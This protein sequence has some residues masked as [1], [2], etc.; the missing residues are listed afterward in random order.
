MGYVVEFVV[1]FVLI[2]AV[3]MIAYFITAGGVK[4]KKAAYQAYINQNFSLLPNKDFL[5][6][7]QLSQKLNPTIVL[8]VDDSKKDIIILMP[9]G[10]KGYT[11][12]IYPQGSLL[13]VFRTYRIITRGA[14]NKTYI[15]E[16]TLILT[17]NDNVSYNFLMWGLGN[18]YGT[19]KGADTVRNIIAPWEQKMRAML[20]IQ[21][22][23]PVPTIQP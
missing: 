13:N 22:P 7:Y 21:P 1:V 5:M 3:Y 18:A 11:Q 8:L 2:F 10:G 20:P 15:Y 4:K 12:K 9:M 19:T 14:I 23:P 16:E 6:A 17:F